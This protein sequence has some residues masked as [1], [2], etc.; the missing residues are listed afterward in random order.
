MTILIV[1]DNEQNQE[2]LEILLGANGYQVVKA[3]NG[4][5]ALAMARQKLPDLVISDILMPV[6]DGFAL[7]RECK[8]DERLRGVPFVFYTATYTDERDREFALGLGAARFIVK[9]EEPGTFMRV[10]REVIEQVQ[11]QSVSSGGPMQAPP[12]EEEGYLQQYN[13]VLVRKLEAKMLELERTNRELEQD[14]AERKRGEEERKRLY[15]QLLQ[16]QKLESLGTLAGGVAHEINNPLMGIMGFTQLIGERWGKHD[17]ELAKFTSEIVRETERVATIVKNLLAFARQ[18]KQS[19]SL[20]RM[21]DIVEGTLSLVRAVLRHDQ[22]AL[23]V[24]VPEDLPQIRCHTQQIQ[25][26]I[27]NAITNAR[28]AL[29]E[30]YP[31]HD[32]NKV[33]RISARMI[34]KSV[35]SEQLAVI[36]DQSAVISGDPDIPRSDFRAPRSYLRLTV[37]DHGTGI[38]EH[39]RERVFDPFFTT[40]PLD[41]GTGL[42]LSI[43]LG[44]VKDHDGTLWFESEVGQWTR[45]H[46]DL[47]AVP[48]EAPQ[49]QTRQA[50]LPVE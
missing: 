11:R 29:N 6:M 47:P 36:G 31:Q 23:E 41:K 5:E 37:E 32:K 1:D 28:D 13:A 27:M 33:V 16:A 24:D 42:G 39:V 8:T 38:P 7:C 21:C 4:A 3:G 44:I 10:I 2:L 45:L 50:G 43:S 20:A 30:K 17:A 49:A 26:V 18:D 34:E 19:R 15:A 9:P 12:V 40:K 35:N 14:I 48:A 22:I 25:Q 46:V